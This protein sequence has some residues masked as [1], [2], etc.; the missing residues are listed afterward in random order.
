MLSTFPA[1]RAA[2]LCFFGL[3]LVSGCS[4]NDF[5]VATET[6]AAPSGGMKGQVK[7]GQQPVSGASVMLYAVGTTADGN[8]SQPLLGQPAMTDGN[9]YFNITG[10][11]TCPA[12]SALVYLVATGG[13]PGLPKGTNADLALMVTLGTCGSLQTRAYATVNELTTVAATS[14]LAQYMTSATTVGPYAGGSAGLGAAFMVSSE[15]VDPT[16]GT[17]PGVNVPVGATVPVGLITTLGDVLAGCVNSAGGVAKDGS[18]CGTFLNLTT[19]PGSAAPTDTV[20]ALNE[21][22]LTPGLNTQALYNLQGSMPPFQPALQTAPANFQIGLVYSSSLAVSPVGLNYPATY[23]GYPAAAL[24]VTLTNVGSAALTGLNLNVTGGNGSDYSLDG[25][26]PA[27]LAVNASCV[28]PVTFVPGGGGPRTA[29]LQVMA[30]GVAQ[31]NVG[32]AGSGFGSAA[33]ATFPS[34]LNNTSLFIGASIIYMWPLPVHDQG[35]PGQTSSQ[36]LARFKAAVV[37][38]GY[39]RVVILVGSNDVLQGTPNS[40]VPN[41]QSMVQ[42]A[43]AAGVEVVL[44]QLPPIFQ[45]NNGYEPTVLAVNAGILQLAQQA[46]VLVIDFH[47]PLAGHPEDFQSDGLHPNTAGYALMEQALAGSVSQ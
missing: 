22:A 8:V 23:A 7:G 32:L 18:P 33:P 10:A 38:Q 14:A 26:C 41:L 21:L 6:A 15:L 16:T 4:R 39:Q 36:V 20:R 46:G 11:Y 5:Q 28:L 12:S 19:A 2:L 13:N 25:S 24:S 40:V 31:Q 17:A 37:G 9:G 35:I 3:V 34:S 44:S 29:T 45:N 27:S 1:Q 42:I 30:S 47:T 43:Q